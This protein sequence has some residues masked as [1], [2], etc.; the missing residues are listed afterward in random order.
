VI[1][2]LP[3]YLRVIKNNLAKILLVE[4]DPQLS[5]TIVEWLKREDYLVE[6]VDNGEDALQLLANFKFDV[7]LLDWMLEGAVTGLDVSRQYRK[8]GGK[9][10]IMFLTGMSE[11]ENIEEGLQYAD[12]YLTKPFDPRELSA[13]IRSA[14][15]R[16]AELLPNDTTIGDVTLDK[17]LLTMIVSGTSVQLRRKEFLLLEYLMRHPNHACTPQ[18]LLDAVWPSNSSASIETVRTWISNLRQKLASA[19]KDNFI[20]TIPGAGYQV[21]SRN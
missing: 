21:E 6:C 1:S 9:V 17:S 18:T 7:I 8:A 19:G 2:V 13:R 5:E 15:R 3:S 4:D 10:F 16:P 14:L 20:K 12:D 11:I